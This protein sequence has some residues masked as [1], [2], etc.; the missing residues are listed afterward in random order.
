MDL[1]T[2]FTFVTSVPEQEKALDAAVAYGLEQG[3]DLITIIWSHQDKEQKHH[4]KILY[5]KNLK[6]E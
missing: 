2:E 6:K 4:F 1:T 5:N 3:W